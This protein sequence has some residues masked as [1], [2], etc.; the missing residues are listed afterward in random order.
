MER[1]SKV[2]MGEQKTTGRDHFKEEQ[3]GRIS[4]RD[5]K[6]PP[7]NKENKDSVKLE[8][9]KKKWNGATREPQKISIDGNNTTGPTESP[10]GKDAC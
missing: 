5:N 4:L 1:N 3:E 2:H 10:D 7:R 9:Q 8:Q 6:T